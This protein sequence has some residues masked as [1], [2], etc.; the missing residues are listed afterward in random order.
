MRYF[1]RPGLDDKLRITVGTPEDT[2]AL[3][4]AL[5][6]DVDDAQPPRRLADGTCGGLVML[7]SRRAAG[8]LVLS[9]LFLSRARAASEPVEGSPFGVAAPIASAPARRRIATPAAGG[10]RRTIR[11]RTEGLSTRRR[12]TQ[13]PM[14]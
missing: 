12:R 7:A 1:D 8:A 11:P 10:G 5:S 3:I 14:S 6:D 13:A 4:A 2:D 9:F